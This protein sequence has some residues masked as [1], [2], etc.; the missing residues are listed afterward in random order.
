MTQLKAFFKSA[1]IKLAL[2]VQMMRPQ[3]NAHIRGLILNYI[4]IRTTS[5][6]T[7]YNPQFYYRLAR[8]IVS[9]AG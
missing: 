6:P 3:D 8:L 9:T 7:Q 4:T 1:N 5:R 2:C